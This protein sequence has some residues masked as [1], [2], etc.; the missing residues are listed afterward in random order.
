MNA[1]SIKVDCTTVCI[2]GAELFILFGLFRLISPVPYRG[3]YYHIG[4]GVYATCNPID[5]EAN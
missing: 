5:S 1:I 4:G 3:G 2:P